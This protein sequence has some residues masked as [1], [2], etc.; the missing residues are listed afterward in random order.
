MNI[1]FSGDDN[2]ILYMTTTMVNLKKYLP[3]D[4]ETNFYILFSGERI[5][6]VDKLKA[7]VNR[8]LKRSKV[9]IYELAKNSEEYE[10]LKN[11]HHDEHLSIGAYAL[12]FVADA[13][14]EIDKA[15]YLDLDITIMDNLLPMYKTELGDNYAGVVRHLENSYYGEQRICKNG[16]NFKEYFSK[17]FENK[18]SEA[19]FNTGVQ[20]LN[21]KK[22]RE[23]KCSNLFFDEMKRIGLNTFKSDLE[24]H[25]Q[26]F[27]NSVFYGKTVFLD[28]RYN[29]NVKRES[30]YRKIQNFFPG[31]LYE[32]M[33]MAVSFP[34]II[35]YAGPRKTWNCCR[36]VKSKEWWLCAVKTPFFLTIIKKNKKKLLESIFK[37]KIKFKFIR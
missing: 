27:F 15:L 34:A 31:K 35:H 20:L 25:N 36:V 32:E 14:P 10:F 9:V 19:Y 30:L 16:M 37:R 17:Y 8:K 28:T 7:F 21:L 1:V 12:Y 11:F 18:N 2:Y 23:D 3:S 29:I 6:Y 26:D 13:F 24:Y 22:M 33:E 5:D 4:T